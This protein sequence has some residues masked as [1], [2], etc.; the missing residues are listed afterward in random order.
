MKSGCYKTKWTTADKLGWPGFKWFGELRKFSRLERSSSEPK[1][2]DSVLS[3]LFIPIFIIWSTL[4]NRIS[5]SRRQTMND[6][7]SIPSSLQSVWLIVYPKSSIYLN[8]VFRERRTRQGF[9]KTIIRTP[10][11]TPHY[12]RTSNGWPKRRANIKKSASHNQNVIIT[13]H[14]RDRDF[15]VFFSADV[16]HKCTRDDRRW[17]ARAHS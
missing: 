16:L 14:W 2:V 9:P 7:K 10:E 13:P 3:V 17:G 4:L 11:P 5:Y 1:C 6:Y 8:Q 15:W 12:T